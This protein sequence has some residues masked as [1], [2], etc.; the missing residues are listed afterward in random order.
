MK[1][2]LLTFAVFL[3]SL[4][5]YSS[6]LLQP[7]DTQNTFVFYVAHLFIPQFSS[8]SFY[9]KRMFSVSI[10]ESNTIFDPVYFKN[11]EK[12]AVIDVETSCMSLLYSEKILYDI[13]L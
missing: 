12:N 11:N 7:A 1:N 3:V 8:E 10:S 5:L 4:N 13:E 6:D 9:S 2:L